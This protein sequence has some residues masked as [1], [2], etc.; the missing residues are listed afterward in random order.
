MYGFKNSFHIFNDKS[1]SFALE[2]NFNCVI[3]NFLVPVQ[4]Y[5]IAVIFGLFVE[6]L[7]IDFFSSIYQVI[8]GL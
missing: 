1:T 6:I 5:I 8:C 4:L 2:S 3:D 7:H